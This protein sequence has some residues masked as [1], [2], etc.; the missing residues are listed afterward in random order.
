MIVI[1]VEIVENCS[2]QVL[3][4]SIFLGGGMLQMC[5]LDCYKRLV[6]YVTNVFYVTNLF[7]RHFNLLTCRD[8][9]AL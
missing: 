3:K 2:I 5:M 6:Y 1:H 9:Y 7:L 4:F 8:P